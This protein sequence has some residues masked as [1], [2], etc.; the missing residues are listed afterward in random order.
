[1]KKQAKTSKEPGM[2]QEME[3]GFK[4]LFLWQTWQLHAK[5]RQRLLQSDPQAVRMI[6]ALVRAFYAARWAGN[7]D[8]AIETVM[9]EVIS[10]QSA[11][12]TPIPNDE[13]YAIMR[14]QAV[15]YNA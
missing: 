13:A 2:S 4:E 8:V 1:M 9:D 12:G 5:L 14:L 7:R 11:I 10:G 6:D 15:V 3:N